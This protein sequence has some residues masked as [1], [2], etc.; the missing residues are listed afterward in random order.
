MVVRGLTRSL[1]SLATGDCSTQVP[2][3]LVN[4]SNVTNATRA[5][6]MLG[7]HALRSLVNVEQLSEVAPEGFSTQIMMVRL[8]SVQLQRSLLCHGVPYASNP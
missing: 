6:R 4:T 8:N 2:S 5:A 7:G 3:P 1:A